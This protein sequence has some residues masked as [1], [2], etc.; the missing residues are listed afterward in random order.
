MGLTI[1]VNG[2][3][4]GMPTPKN[5]LYSQNKLW[6]QNTGRLDNGYFV[7]DLIA[8]KKKY[9]VTFPPLT[10][11]DLQHVREAIN[12]DFASIK[13]TNAE[14]GTDEI[15]AYFGDLNVESYSW[16]NGINYAIN[17][18]VSMIER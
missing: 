1:N 16:H 9:E 14:G 5:V 11:T 2:A 3:W 6:S 18:T 17:A 8:V 12:Q 13:I 4:V 10:P 7:G 15:T